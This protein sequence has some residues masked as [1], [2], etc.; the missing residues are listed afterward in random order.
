MDGL[1][2]K[3][4]RRRFP[5]TGLDLPLEY[6]VGELPWAHGVLTVNASE[7]GLLIHSVVNLTVGTKLNILVL[8]PQEYKLSNFAVSAQIVWKEI[9]WKEDWEG[10]QCGLEF[11]ELSDE[12]HWKLR[13]ILNEQCG[14]GEGLMDC[15]SEGI[16]GKGPLV[17]C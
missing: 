5:R 13:Q 11:I 9:C 17:Y 16:N 6:R 10:F 2:H 8:F 12:D 15:E 14:G 7:T 4:E 1:P 3:E